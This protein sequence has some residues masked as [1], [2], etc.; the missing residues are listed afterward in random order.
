[1]TISDIKMVSFSANITNQTKNIFLKKKSN[2]TKNIKKKKIY[3]QLSQSKQFL[4]NVFFQIKGQFLM[5]QFKRSL[6]KV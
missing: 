3:K 1:M 4:S 6:I 2:N 5:G